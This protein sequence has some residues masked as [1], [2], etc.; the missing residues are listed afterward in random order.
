MRVLVAGVYCD[1]DFV[2]LAVHSYFV[3]VDE[4]FGSKVVG[5]AAAA[6]SAAVAT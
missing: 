2:S 6:D 4:R 5:R 1:S 3:E